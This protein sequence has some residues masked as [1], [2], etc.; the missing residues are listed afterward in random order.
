MLQSKHKSFMTIEEA[1]NYLGLKVSTLYMYVHRRVIPY[2]K[3]RRRVY[4]KI[5]DLDNFV[6][7]ENCRNK[8]ESEIEIDALA[9]MEVTS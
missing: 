6:L 4:F 7:N 8:S 2:Y 5:Q 3:P 1:S 9:H